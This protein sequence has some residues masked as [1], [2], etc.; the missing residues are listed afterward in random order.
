MSE[1]L[2][3]QGIKRLLEGRTAVIVAH[4]LS[5]IRD[6]DRIMVVHKGR[7]VESG[8]HQELLDQDGQYAKLYRIQFC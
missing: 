1:R 2:I 4:R 5:T 7:I 3:Q 8:T 6:A